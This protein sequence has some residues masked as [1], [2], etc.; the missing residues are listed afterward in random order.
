MRH[1]IR[2]K[3]FLVFSGFMAVFVL[4]GALFNI[5]LSESFYI[6]KN[7][8][9]FIETGKNIADEYS[10]NKD[11]IESYIESVDREDGVSVVITS[12]SQTIL[13]SSYSKRQ[14]DSGSK[15]PKELEDYLAE[16]QKDIDT[17]YAYGVV[18]KKTD[19]EP[20]LAYVKK[21]SDGGFLIMTRPIKGIRESVAIYN[22]F[23]IVLGSFIVILSG[24]FMFIFS[25][26]ITDPIVEMS[27]V[28][29]KISNLEFENKIDV[30]SNDEIGQ[31]R[32][33]INTISEKLKVSVDGLKEDIEFQ[34]QFARDLSHELKTPIGVIKG[35][36]EG[37]LF[38]IADDKEMSE[39]YCHV[40][41]DECDRMDKMVKDLL[42][43]SI[44]EAKGDVFG[45]QTVFEMSFLISSVI[46]RF[47][48]IFKENEITCECKYE[49]E[50][51]VRGDYELLER[52]VSNIVINAVK[53]NNE[54][55]YIKISLSETSSEIC[56]S[57][58]NTG[59]PIPQD[60]IGKIWDVFYKVDKAR[61]RQTGGHGLG[62][63]IVKSIISLHNG[64]VYAEN[65]NDGIEFV[66]CLPK[67]I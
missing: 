43:I 9:I 59:T 31:L 32:E 56:L 52:A 14:T 36:A 17:S 67:Q 63:S 42:D 13:F 28:A 55:R 5:L 45:S 58:F 46:E 62:L 18:E 34:K 8:D 25:K 33:S 10:L 54:K 47:E 29:E 37:L 19:Q 60:Q 53:Y 24:A 23:Y 57:V 49:D 48:P 12:K 6:Y 1:S 39:K 50:I 35:Y 11:N 66:I 20:K 26:K 21:L 16:N 51:S 15:L 27:E 38:G 2:T 7:K 22:Q 3:L 64:R 4:L 41:A 61:T 65:K 44:L 40:I 30:T